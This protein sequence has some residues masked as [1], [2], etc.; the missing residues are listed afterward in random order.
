MSPFNHP[1]LAIVFDFGGV[2]LDWN[3][4]YLYRKLF[5]GDPN[6][7]ERFLTE[8]GFVEWNLQQDKGRPLAVAVA[9]L[10]E[11]FP[12]Y[13]DLIQA[14]DERWPE[15]IAGP[16]QP[17]VNILYALKQAGY[18]LYGLSNWSAETFQRVRH[19][20]AFLDWFETIVVS[21]DVK[22]VKPDPRIYS[23][24]L[25]RVGRTAGECLFIDDSEANVAVAGQLGFKT[26]RF[27]S[28][29]QLARELHQRGLTLEKPSRPRGF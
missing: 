3:P 16:I 10:S 6:A 9:E 18:P 19:R 1:Y 23:V 15:S 21:G 5:N 13:A 11:R 24:F 8:I 12:Q 2:L 27:E 26:I 29:E 20:Y 25:E 28:P 17:T 7:M 14:Y 4:R 22:L